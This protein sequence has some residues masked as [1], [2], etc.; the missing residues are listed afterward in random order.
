MLCFLNINIYFF[1]FLKV[2]LQ[3]NGRCL[4]KRTIS[5]NCYVFL[6]LLQ[7]FKHKHN[8]FLFLSSDNLSILINNANCMVK[9]SVVL[10]SLFV[11]ISDLSSSSFT[12][13]S[14]SFLLLLF[15]V[16]FHM[17]KQNNIISHFSLSQLS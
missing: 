2:Y 8:K 17:Y 3:V 12:S 16:T 4:L 6:I 1:E 9:L 15:K 11:S 10:R 14:V 13:S 5:K 7:M